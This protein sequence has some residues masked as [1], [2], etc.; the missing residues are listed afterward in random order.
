MQCYAMLCHAMPCYAITGD[1]GG[2]HRHQ[3]APPPTQRAR[4][5]RPP[6]AYYE[7]AITAFKSAKTP[8]IEKV[9]YGDA[10][11]RRVDFVKERLV[12]ITW[13]R[14]PDCDKYLDENGVKRPVAPGLAP[15][16]GDPSE[17]RLSER[18]VAPPEYDEPEPGLPAWARSRDTPDA[19]YAPSGGG[20]RAAPSYAAERGTSG[21][22]RHAGGLYAQRAHAE[23]ESRER[24]GRAHEE[25]GSDGRD[26]DSQEAARKE[27]L[28]YHLQVGE[29]DKAEELV[30]TAEEREDLD[31]LRERERREQRPGGLSPPRAAPKRLDTSPRFGRQGQVG[32]VEPPRVGGA[33]QAQVAPPARQSQ[34]PPDLMGDDDDGL[35]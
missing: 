5:A 34:P 32:G 30:V 16:Q 9:I 19:P 12:D 20:A 21:R 14:K 6:Q 8:M 7:Q 27:W 24:Y 28:Q 35:L 31:Y 22:E 1:E 15:P 23:R 3:H 33:G 11:K 2:T 17:E 10:N 29:W 4:C 13:G 18:W 26:D 25:A